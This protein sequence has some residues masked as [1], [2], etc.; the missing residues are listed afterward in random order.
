MT[1][2]LFAV[3]DTNV[4]ISA[5]TSPVDDSPPR[6]ILRAWRAGRFRAAWCDELLAEWQRVCARPPISR[7]H[8]LSAREQMA[9]FRILLRPAAQIEPKLAAPT[10]PDPKDQM[11]W[12]ML[13][14]HPALLLVTGDQALLD[15]AH[16]PDRKYRPADFAARLSR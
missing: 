15:S 5:L 12:G 10:A 13:A 14:A 6:Q 8:G 1:A 16:Y 4:L 9:F 11:L 3:I 2:P 7:R